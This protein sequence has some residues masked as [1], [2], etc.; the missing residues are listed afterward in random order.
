VS[1]KL[2]QLTKVYDQQIA[3]DHVS[4][5]AQKG[6]ILG[7]L[8]PNGAGK[9]SIMKMITGFIPPTSGRILVSGTDVVLEP[10]ETKKLIGYLPEN[11][12]LYL[13]M[14]VHEYLRFSGKTYGLRKSHLQER[15][16]Q[17]IDQ[18]GLAPEQHKFIGQLSKGYRQRV[19]LAQALLH[20]PEVLILDEP[21]TGLDPNQIIE[22]RDLIRGTA[23]EKTVIFSSHIMQEVQA[24][25]DDIVI[26]KNGRMVVSDTKDNIQ[27]GAEDTVL[28]SVTFKNEIQP[29]QFADVEGV[30]E[31]NRL[32]ANKLAFSC[33]RQKDPRETIFKLAAEQGNPI[34][35][36]N[37]EGGSIEQAFTKLTKE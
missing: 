8:G 19:G 6:R 4:F 25:C 36:M 26:L 37:V 24:L 10:I 7:L 32:E 17:V 31:V 3:V 16:K 33:D 13:D 34:F 28:L 29:E 5:E 18:V 20:Q 14:Y 30:L 21:T 22:I 12:P 2:D 1:V 35:Q 27:A 15:V 23:R 11:N 9:S